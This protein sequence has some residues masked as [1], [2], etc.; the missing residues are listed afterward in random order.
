MFRTATASHSRQTPVRQVLRQ[1][2]SGLVAPSRLAEAARVLRDVQAGT[3]ATDRTTVRQT[4]V[5]FDSGQRARTGVLY[6][7]ASAR[8]GLLLVPGAAQ[9]G[10]DDPR[11]TAFAQAL[12]RA[13]LEVLVPHLAGLHELRVGAGDA[14]VIADALSALAMHRASQG[15][16][17]V[18]MIAICY[19]TGPA[20]LA[21]LDERVM[22]TA[23]FML[24]IGGY[25]D[26]NA[27][28]KFM[29]TGQYFDP[30]DDALH[31]RA[32]DEYA[33]WVFALSIA[34]ALKDGRDRELLESMAR[35]RLADKSADLSGL[36][37]GLGETGRHVLALLEN[38][39][40][41]R[42]PALIAALPPHIID[43]IAGLDLSHRDLSQLD[44]HFT[45]IH[46]N[47][48]AVIPET[49]SIAL[50]GALPRADLF[51]LDSI[52]HVDP[53]PAGLADKLKLLA[54]I[55][56]LLRQRDK[57]RQPNTLGATSPLRAVDD[58]VQSA[59]ARR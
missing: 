30:R 38:R 19:S 8:A 40:P 54:A 20:M 46:G 51:I 55:H 10:T 27:V 25:R 34:A 21:L 18:G 3:S 29:T 37:S 53:G 7:T 45:L 39:D 43:E 41:D 17:T 5:V 31:R 24:A 47:D 44:M 57:H 50:A 59:E 35:T 12:A 56:T 49:E 52:R 42:V 16:A 58:P 36:E 48:D 1:L 14:D 32:P 26:I 2:F 22:G 6:G 9:L 13:R 33:K 23:Q 11:F 15:N 28:I 4:T